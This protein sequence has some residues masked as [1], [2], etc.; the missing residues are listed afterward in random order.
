MAAPTCPLSPRTTP[1]P[2]PKRRFVKLRLS[3]QNLPETFRP[4]ATPGAVR[5]AGSR[6]WR[7]GTASTLD[8]Q[9]LQTPRSLAAVPW[10][11]ELASG[12]LGRLH[13]GLDPPVQSHPQL[14]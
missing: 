8:P 10:E 1:L 12:P 14:P 5:E 4:T 9:P 7:R 11:G 3:E 2:W 13:P 6:G